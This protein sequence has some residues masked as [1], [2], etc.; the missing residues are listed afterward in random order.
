MEQELKTQM[1]QSLEMVKEMLKKWE[2]VHEIA[3]DII[4]YVNKDLR[5][6]RI[7]IDI[8]VG[9]RIIRGYIRGTERYIH[10]GESLN[11]MTLRQIYER[12][13]EDDEALVNMIKKLAEAIA[14]VAEEKA[15][16]LE[17]QLEE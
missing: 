3:Q 7:E 5:K 1:G 10:Y 14:E 12:F 15:K 6:F 9:M 2:K 17:E 11:E 4:A 13:F 8:A 16:E